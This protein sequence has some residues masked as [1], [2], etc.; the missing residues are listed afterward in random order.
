LLNTL[1]SR[2]PKWFA[3]CSPPVFALDTG[4]IKVGS[5]E[6]NRALYRE[7][8]RA[9]QAAGLPASWSVHVPPAVLAERD[10]ALAM[11]RTPNQE[12]LGDPIPGRSAL[13]RRRAP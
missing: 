2:P 7:A 13:D 3:R 6:K 1:A 9:K 5:N 12:I 11:E 8:S 10:R 4:C